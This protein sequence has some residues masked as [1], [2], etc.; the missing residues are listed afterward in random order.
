MAIDIVGVIYMG[1]QNG[2]TLHL[3]VLEYSLLVQSQPYYKCIIP[4]VLESFGIADRKQRPIISF[5]VII[6]L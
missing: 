5:F 3:E 6:N 2:N 1:C 4:L